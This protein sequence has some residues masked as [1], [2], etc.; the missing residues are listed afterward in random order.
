[1]KIKLNFKKSLIAFSTLLVGFA[2][3][4]SNTI[5]YFET[6]QL[7]MDRIHS[8][9]GAALVTHSENLKENIAHLRLGVT[10]LAHLVEDRKDNESLAYTAS[11][12]A[13]LMNAD[14][15]IIGFNND[16]YY[17]SKL[18]GIPSSYKVTQTSW[19][20]NTKNSDQILISNV[21]T[22]VD[23]SR[24]FSIS[25]RFSQGV[26]TAIIDVKYLEHMVNQAAISATFAI[27]IEADGTVVY[28]NNPAVVPG[29]NT[30]D[31]VPIMYN[32]V[33]K[34]QDLAR[35]TQHFA[36]ENEL[37]LMKKIDLGNTQWFL[38][39]GALESKA[40][41]QLSPVRNKAIVTIVI[42]TLIAVV[43]MLFLLRVLYKP[44]L[45]LRDTLAELAKG[46]GD[47]T[48]RLEV[49]NENDDLGIITGH[50]NGWI[51]N[52]QGMMQD[53]KALSNNLGDVISEINELSAQN[54]TAL[55][56]H[57]N[58]T[59]MV[60]TAIEELSAT[61]KNV[62][63]NALNAAEL[64]DSANA[65]GESSREIVTQAQNNVLTLV[66]DVRATA[67][68]VKAMGQKTDNISSM[69]EVIGGVAEQTNLLALNAAIEAARAGEYGRGFAVVADEVRHLASRT[70]D[71]TT[72]IDDAVNAVIESSNAIVDKMESTSQAGETA[73]H[74]AEMVTE[75]LA[76]LTQF[77]GDMNGIASQIADAAGEQT[78]VTDEVT[79]S[80]FKIS[81][82]ANQVNSN[83]NDASNSVE[84]MAAMYSQLSS[85]VSAFKID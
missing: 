48:Q 8:Q 22:G 11:I 32:E 74:E 51:E 27:L 42:A 75:S 81:E 3:T 2:V 20:K 57:V 52:N 54:I 30:K 80:I 83:V 21:F 26:V 43:V 47:L 58:Q 5:S 34:A 33:I 23:G 85:M 45:Q 25:K 24:V 12:T 71:N 59:E 13:K 1:M 66:D 62:T 76:R 61:S 63:Q 28:T 29:S 79:Q 36:G 41:A 15:V 16:E 37:D 49:I 65:T 10:E 31:F 38:A 19:F 18:D 40:Y 68:N 72:E 69:T 39:T 82:M 44:L 78:R 14:V 56:D 6:E 35:F 4:I 84:T 64:A 50:I 46:K 55:S 9:M 67:E 70:Q 77:I 53:I 17:S 60:V 73:A 7:L